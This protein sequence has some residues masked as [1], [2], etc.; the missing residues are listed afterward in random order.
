RELRELRFDV[1]VSIRTY[2]RAY[3][4]MKLLAVAGFAGPGAVLDRTG[5]IRVTGGRGKRGF[6]LVLEMAYELI[7]GPSLVGGPRILAHVVWF[8]LIRPALT[9]LRTLARAVVFPF[10]VF[11][12]AIKAAK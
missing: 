3:D 9:A 7:G 2:E 12:L 6:A 5:R 10:V 8:G 11:G 1:I 4:K